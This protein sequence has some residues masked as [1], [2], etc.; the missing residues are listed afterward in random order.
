MAAKGCSLHMVFLR[1]EILT[2]VLLVG[3]KIYCA[4][5]PLRAPC[6]ISRMEFAF[7]SVVDIKGRPF[8][9][10]TIDTP[11]P[12]SARVMFTWRG[13]Q[14]L[15]RLFHNDVAVKEMVVVYNDR[16]RNDTVAEIGTG[17]NCF[18]VGF[19]KGEPASLRCSLDM[20]GSGRLH[21]NR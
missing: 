11:L 14:R 4:E 19:V 6:D 1:I 18:H 5:L 16:N 9:N 13:R 20:H 21:T 17:D 15:L 8:G 2:M 10:W 7:P 12:A 3:Q